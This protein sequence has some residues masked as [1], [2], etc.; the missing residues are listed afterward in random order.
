MLKWTLWIPLFFSIALYAHPHIFATAFISVA[1]ETSGELV[2]K[3]RWVFDELYSAAKIESIGAKKDG[4]V[5][6]AE[7]LDIER[8]VVQMAQRFNYYNYLL[9]G[10]QF[11]AAKDY[12]N[13]VVKKEGKRLVVYFDLSFNLKATD[14]YTILTLAVR[15][16]SSYI[17]I[18]LDI[19]KVEVDAP[20]NIEVEY[21]TDV[22]KGLTLFKAFPPTMEGLYLRFRKKP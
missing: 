4:E 19:S 12:K 22:L 10:T 8:S 1:F 17:D 11:M 2:I 21:F 16:L 14:D 9:V 18:D 15:D 13:L 5:S 20:P 3:N 7:M 6:K